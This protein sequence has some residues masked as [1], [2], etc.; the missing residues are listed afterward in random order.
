MTLYDCPECALPATSVSRG[1]WESTNGPVEHVF[2]RC[3]AG[4]R[5]LGPAE[6]LIG[7][8]GERATRDSPA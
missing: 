1:T 7:S 6:M 2:V 3:V 4:H 5:F 8:R